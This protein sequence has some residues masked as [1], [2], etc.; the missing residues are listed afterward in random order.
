MRG[1]PPGQTG[2]HSLGP[3]VRYHHRVKTHGRWRRRQ[4]EPG[5]FLWR[6]PLGYH[7]L[8]NNTGTHPLGTGPFAQTIWCAAAAGKDRERSTLENLVR[9]HLEAIP[10]ITIVWPQGT[11][12]VRQMTRARDRPD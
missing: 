6:S 12:P 1:V 8:V 7:Y 5:V 9:A 3:M 11:D 2:P 10:K 4:P